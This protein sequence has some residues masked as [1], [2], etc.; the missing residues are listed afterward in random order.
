MKILVRLTGDPEEVPMQIPSHQFVDEN[1]DLI[2]EQPNRTKY[3]SRAGHDGGTLF[4]GDGV[5]STSERKPARD[6]AANS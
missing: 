5:K 3:S 4:T 1:T 6:D 2:Y